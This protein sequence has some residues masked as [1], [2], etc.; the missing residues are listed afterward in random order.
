MNTALDIACHY[1]LH[2]GYTKTNMQVLKLTYIAHGYSLAIRDRGLFEDKVKVWPWGPVIPSVYNKFKKWGS[3]IIGKIPY[4]PDE[5]EKEDKSI[6]DA[7]YV[8]YGKYCGYYLSQITHDDDDGETPWRQCKNEDKLV[9][10]D[11]YTKEYYRKKIANARRS[12]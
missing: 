4:T 9:I 3:G 6:F 2:S 12:S 5:L 7:V 8:V 10:P 1:V 11:E